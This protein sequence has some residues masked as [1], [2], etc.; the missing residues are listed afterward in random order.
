MLLY[1][2]FNS[3]LSAQ[4]APPVACYGY[5]Q[6][7]VR[8]EW[9]GYKFTEKT[10]VKGAHK[11]V[12]TKIKGAPQSVNEMIAATSFEVDVMSVD[13]ANP[14]RDNTLRENFFKL[15]KSDKITGKI[16]SLKDSV[17]QV[18]LTMNGTT[19][20]VAF[21]VES[22]DS[23]IS[24]TAAIDILDFGMSPSLKKINEVCYELHK[25][26]DGI[27]KTWSTVDLNITAEPVQLCKKKG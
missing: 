16:L 1:F 4:A 18:E 12:S 6:D 24:A 22:S 8:I 27:S 23:K 13:T 10:G 21:K 3:L 14:A 25:G 11:K 7:S 17:A 5:K 26:T 9:T 15:M 19:K 20:T 2:I